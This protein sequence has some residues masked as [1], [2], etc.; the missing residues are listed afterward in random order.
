VA[1]LDADQ[2]SLT[3][4]LPLPGTGSLIGEQ[5]IAGLVYVA[6]QA[7]DGARAWVLEPHVESA[8]SGTIG[9]AVFDATELPGTAAGDGL[10]RGGTS[11]A[12]DRPPA[13]HHRVGRGRGAL[14]RIDAG[15]NAFAWRLAGA[16]FGALLVA[17]IYLLAATMFSRRRIAVLAAVFVALDGMSYAM[18]RIAM[19]DIFV[20][21]FI[22]AAFLLFWQVWSG[23]WSR[24]AWWVLPLVGVVIG[25]AAATKWV[26]FYGLAG[27]WVLVLARS[28]LGRL[29]LV[30]LVAMAAVVGGI[31]APWPFLL[32]MLGIGAVALA[33]TWARP[34]RIDRREALL[35]IP[36]T[37]AVL[38][39]VALAFV[40]AF[41]VESGRSRTGRWSS[42]SPSWL[43]APRLPGQPGSCSGWPGR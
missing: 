22:V 42:S 24:S 35:A 43:V 27:L 21:V 11:Q 15:S 5:R 23:R 30:A 20:A 37:T 12:D 4:L 17:L 31:G 34:I 33:I 41:G 29:V 6:G 9:L 25:L 36:A 39:G 38:A 40:V 16:L 14:V 8:G 13:A 1:A 28:D 18:S 26:G 32:T 3:G 7:E 19:N 2:G 10:R